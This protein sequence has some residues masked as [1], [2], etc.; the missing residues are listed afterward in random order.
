[1]KINHNEDVYFTPKQAADYFNLSLSTIKNYIYAGK[2]KTLKTPGGHHRISKSE[3][4]ATLG[5]RALLREDSAGP[6]SVMLLSNVML[7]MFNS[8]GRLGQSLSLHAQNVSRLC[9]EA[10]KAMAMDEKNI[11]IVKM[12]GLIHDIGHIGVD[13][14]ILLKKES[15]STQEYESVKD[16][17]KIGFQILDSIKDLKDV[18]AI[19][20]QHHE[21]VDGTG[22]P[23]GLKGERIKKSARIIS[24]AEAYD[25]MVSE[26]SYKR[27]ISKESAMAELRNQK[28][29]QF[30]AEIV[31]V[32]VRSVMPAKAGI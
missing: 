27:P 19:V 30:D 21:W 9:S 24:V 22:Y 25:S 17:P 2:L 32:F 8:L 6:S 23:K 18:A 26:H 4:L 10:A 20:L 31:D 3:L 16:H 12:A 28:G 14:D 13:K 7:A 15:L 1:M 29:T 5:H 11:A